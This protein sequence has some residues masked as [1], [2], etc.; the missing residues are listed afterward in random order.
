MKVRP[1]TIFVTEGIVPKE[2]SMFFRRL[3]K[4]CHLALDTKNLD[5]ITALLQGKTSQLK[6]L[7]EL[8]DL[9]KSKETPSLSARIAQLVEQR[10]ENPRVG[11]SNPPSGT[12]LSHC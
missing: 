6:T 4:N 12:I 1:T 5:V 11:G 8:R 7:K 2:L 9:N 10:I 3:S